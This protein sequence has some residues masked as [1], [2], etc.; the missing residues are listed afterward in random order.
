M[1]QGT[2]LGGCAQQMLLTIVRFIVAFL[3]SEMGF[4]WSGGC[5]RDIE[6]LKIYLQMTLTHSKEHQWSTA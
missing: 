6:S 2:Q 4:N 1:Q 3:P 5:S